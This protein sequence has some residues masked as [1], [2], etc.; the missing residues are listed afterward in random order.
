MVLH[1]ISRLNSWLSVDEQ[2]DCSDQISNVCCS[3]A[4]YEVSRM[5]HVENT[6]GACC[7][8]FFPFIPKTSNPALFLWL[9]MLTMNVR[10]SQ[11]QKQATHLWCQI[12]SGS[13]KEWLMCRPGEEVLCRRLRKTGKNRRGERWTREVHKYLFAIVCSPTVGFS[14]PSFVSLNC[15]CNV[16]MPDSI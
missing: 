6:D 16:Y 14:C 2:M 15:Y 11:Q 3:K 1:L 7:V 9:W 8:A 12:V 10:Q 5:I 13:G 4:W